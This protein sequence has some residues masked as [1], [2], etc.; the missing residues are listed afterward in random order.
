ME[1]LAGHCAVP[2]EKTSGDFGLKPLMTKRW[3][4]LNSWRELNHGA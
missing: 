3:L 2:R 4:L 1:E